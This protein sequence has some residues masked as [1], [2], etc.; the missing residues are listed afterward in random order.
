MFR[1]EPTTRQQLWRRPIVH[2]LALGAVLFALTRTSGSAGDAGSSLVIALTADRIAEIRAEL[3]S[4]S[5][6]LDDEDLRVLIDAAIDE[7]ILYR[8]AVARGLD[9]NDAVVERRLVQSMRFVAE[10]DSAGEAVLLR[11]A[12]AAGL[13]EGDAVIRRRLV[14]KMK[15]ALEREAG[16]EPPSE[17]QLREYFDAH[18]AEL[19]AP[20]RVRM[21]Q[22]F[23]SGLQALEKAAAELE[24]LRR[25]GVKPEQSGGRGESFI[26]G[27]V[28]P[29]HS[30]HGLAKLFGPELARRSMTL[31][32]NQWSGPV[33]SAYGAHIIWIHER[34]APVNPRFET[35]RG[36]VRERIEAE[37]SAR[38]VGDGLKRLRSRYIVRVNSAIRH[39]P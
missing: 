31:P 33:R 25:A 22:L 15:F 27:A 35:V 29:E 20:P 18:V 34:T 2:F 6:A 23:F 12:L 14:Q 37:Q 36:L 21:T 17:R 13:F 26:A 16:T 8:E 19:S 38:A 1:A 39:K 3:A 28:L 7:E 5:G 24:E 30:E 4:G 32:V 11:R 10:D 9:A